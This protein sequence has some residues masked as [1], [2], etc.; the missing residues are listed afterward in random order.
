MSVRSRAV[1][2]LPLRLTTF[3]ALPAVCLFLTCACAPSPPGIP[4]VL[5]EGTGTA[6]VNG[7]VETGEWAKA[8][9]TTFPVKVP[10]G[11]TVTAEF[12]LMNDA[13]NLYALLSY[14]RTT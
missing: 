4:A 14:S 6:T 5:F 1:R 7:K 11:S 9:C 2:N 12:C 13:K 3:F 8:D 10:G